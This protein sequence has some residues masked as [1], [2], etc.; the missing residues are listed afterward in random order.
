M[1]FPKMLRPIHWVGVGA[2]V[3]VAAVAVSMLGAGESGRADPTDPAQV[4]LGSA[5]YEANCASCHGARLEGQANWRARKADGKLPAPPHDASGHTW[6]HPDKL[7][8]R[9]TKFGP[10]AVASAGYRSDM[11]AYQDELSDREIWAALAYI[12]SRW[13]ANVRARQQEIDRRAR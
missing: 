11:P 8:F 1:S 7:L 13:P 9:I 5:V 10:A 12:K 2:V 6:H 3:I 4:A